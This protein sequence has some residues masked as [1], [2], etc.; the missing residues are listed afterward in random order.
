MCA[1]HVTLVE[2]IDKKRYRIDDFVHSATDDTG[3]V[4]LACLLCWM[5]GFKSFLFSNESTQITV[6][7]K[8]VFE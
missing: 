3:M 8:K 7:D 2:S 6:V 4:I 1:P 5:V